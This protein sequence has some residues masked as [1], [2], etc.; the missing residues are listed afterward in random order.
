MDRTDRDPFVSRGQS[1]FTKVIPGRPWMV[2]DAPSP[3]L[4]LEE[5]VVEE[6]HHGSS[7]CWSASVVCRRRRPRRSSEHHNS[8]HPRHDFRIEPPTLSLDAL[9]VLPTYEAGERCW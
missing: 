3:V 4:A 1:I 6:L 5:Q 9:A 7:V 8:S 2:A